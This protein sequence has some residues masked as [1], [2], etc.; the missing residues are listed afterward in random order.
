MHHAKL[1]DRVE[2]KT[3][4]APFGSVVKPVIAT[5]PHASARTVYWVLDN[6]S[7]HAGKTSI[8]RIQDRWP[9]ARLIHVPVHTSWLNQIALCFSILQRDALT[10][11][12][13][14]TPDALTE[15]LLA[16]GQHYR[17]IARTFEWTFTRQDLDA[18]L[19]YI[20]RTSSNSRSPPEHQNYG[21]LH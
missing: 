1:F 17:H 19:A 15:R 11:N 2:S 6:G 4:I 20:D 5:Q 3:A 8:Q 7:S 12:D 10:P 16:F 14:P 13:L 18:S 21:C 9:N